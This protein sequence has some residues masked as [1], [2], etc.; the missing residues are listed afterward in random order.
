MTK[1]VNI[2][3]SSGAGKSTLSMGLTYNLKLEGNQVELV[4]EYAKSVVL[5]ES[6]KKLNFQYYIFAKQLKSLDLVRNKGLDYVVTDSP[7]ILALFY[8]KKYGTLVPYLPELILDQFNS[9]ENIN[10]FLNRDHHFD[11]FGRVQD[12]LESDQDSLNLKSMLNEYNIPYLEFK[13]SLNNS[14]TLNKVLNSINTF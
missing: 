4:T 10:I 7:L 3:G 11:P 12:E 2:F 5:E 14:D 9:M 13:T 1:I 6:Y 8:G